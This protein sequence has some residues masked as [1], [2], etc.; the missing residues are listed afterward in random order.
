M[1]QLL[2]NSITCKSNIKLKLFK[3]KRRCSRLLFLEY[4]K[5]GWLYNRNWKTK[6]SL[7]THITLNF[8][9]LDYSVKGEALYGLYKTADGFGIT[10]CLLDKDG[11]EWGYKDMSE[12][13][14]PVVYDCPEKFLKMSTNQE[15]Y[16][17]TWRQACRDKRQNKRTWSFVEGQKVRFT[18]DNLPPCLEGVCEWTTQK[19]T[20]LSHRPYW[21]IEGD[22]RRFRINSKLMFELQA[23]AL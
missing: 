12:S 1:F 19:V 13:N 15:G 2:L 6:E 8:N 16:A 10:V 4:Y 17:P 14:G 9:F 11:L 7:V 21:V 23:V 22:S 18:T 3:L 5:M 20:T